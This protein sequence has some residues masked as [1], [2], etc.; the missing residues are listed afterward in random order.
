M[1]SSLL[2][3]TSLIVSFTANTSAE[4]VNCDCGFYQ[5][6]TGNTW[7]NIHYTNWNTYTDNIN[8]DSSFI[9]AS[10]QV[11]AKYDNILTRDYTSN[12]VKISDR[13]LELLVTPESDGTPVK[14]SSIST[15]RKDILYGSFR[16]VMKI[17]VQ[18][19]TVSAFYFYE[20]DEAELDIELLSYIRN[21]SQV[22]WAIHPSIKLSNGAAD[23]RTHGTVNMEVD[24]AADF[25]EYRFDWMPGKASFFIDGKFYNSFNTNIPSVPGKMIFN[26]WTDGN[27]NFSKGPPTETATLSILNHSFFF[28]TTDKKELSCKARSSSCSVA[29]ILAGNIQPEI[30]SLAVQNQHLLPFLTVLSAIFMLL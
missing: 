11:P 13:G 10:Y 2:V 16:A 12:N 9:V 3:L 29:D 5:E 19:G 6:D 28:N 30:Q 4:K 22:Y 20:S 18:P 23:P 7:S 27:P 14:S 15:S 25:H 8:K 17:P 26:H 24:A 1:V 21:P